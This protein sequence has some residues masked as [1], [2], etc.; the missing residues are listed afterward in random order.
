M[1][2]GLGFILL[3]RFIRGLGSCRGLGE[4]G[5]KFGKVF[6]WL[7]DRMCILS[8]GG[9]ITGRGFIFGDVISR[10]LKWVCECGVG[11]AARLTI[12]YPNARSKSHRNLAP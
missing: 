3:W 8:G 6:S 12:R 2:L 11:E 10:G 5:W 4:R 9:L 7:S 1:C